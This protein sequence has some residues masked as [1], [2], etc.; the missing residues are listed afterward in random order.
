[1]GSYESARQDFEVPTIDLSAYLQDPDSTEA[2]D[3][4]DQIRNACAT[5]GFFQ[6][7]GHGIPKTLQQQAFTSARTLFNLSAEEKR[8]LCGNP[9]RG[10]EVMGKQFLEPGKQPDLKEVSLNS[11]KGLACSIH[12]LPSSTSSKAGS[13]F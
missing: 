1:M 3:V 8:N 10:Y 11:R 2:N 5:S 13:R 4:V 9:G 6:L 7:T 12:Q